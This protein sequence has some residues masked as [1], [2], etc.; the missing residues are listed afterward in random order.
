MIAQIIIGATRF[1]VGGHARWE[2]SAPAPRQRIYF[3][4]HSSHLDTVILWAALPKELRT[5]THPVAALDY[6]GRTPLHRFV[7]TK[8]LNAVLVDRSARH[9][10]LGPLTEAL[11]RG[12]SLILFPEGTRHSEAVPGPFKGGL[13]HLARDYPGVELVPVYLTN[14][15]RAYPKGAILPAPISCVVSFGKPLERWADE[16]KPLFLERARQAVCALGDVR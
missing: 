11:D 4:N 1:L 5:T 14:L 10:P 2:G 12:H 15:A 6:W 8:V 9:D 16:P 7:A 13:H 3:A